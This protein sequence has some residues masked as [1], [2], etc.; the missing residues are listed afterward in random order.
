MKG[1]T[2]Q[3]DVQEA[4]GQ[5][6]TSFQICPR[7]QIRRRQM[8]TCQQGWLVGR[9]MSA[10]KCHQRHL[11][12]EGSK[13]LDILIDSHIPSTK[14]ALRRLCGVLSA[15]VPAWDAHL[16]QAQST[17]LAAQAGSRWGPSPHALGMPLWQGDT[18]S[19]RAGLCQMRKSLSLPL[20]VPQVAPKQTGP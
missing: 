6:Q 5:S 18:A 10:G 2:V 3:T 4:G 7:T 1:K 19:G 12:T 9:S 8:R 11:F 15:V 14:E 13:S 17:R 20:L 16:L